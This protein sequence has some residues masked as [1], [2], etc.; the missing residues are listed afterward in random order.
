MNYNNIESITSG[1]IKVLN[2]SSVGSPPPIPTPLIFTGVPRRQGL[3]AIRVAS[4]IIAR[5][6]EAGLPVGVLPSGAVSPEEKMWRIV[7]EEIYKDIQLNAVVSVAIP[8][9]ITLSAAGLS[10]A[11]PVSVF[12]AT[13]TFNRGYGTIQ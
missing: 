9:G 2:L 1:F 7:V 12:G 11:G 8:P 5:K 10:P 3:S 6:S 13:I 4:K